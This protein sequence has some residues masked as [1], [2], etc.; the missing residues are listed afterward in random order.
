MASTHTVGDGKT[1]STIQAGIDDV[2]GNRSGQGEGAVEVYAKAGD[3]AETLNT[4]TGFSN[5]SAADF[6]SVTAMVSHDGVRD[7]G[8]IVDV[9]STTANQ[10]ISHGLWAVLDGFCIFASSHKAAST[11]WLINA[12]A[13][14]MVRNCII[15]DCD[16]DT[17]QLVHGIFL[18]GA[19]WI[20]NCDVIGIGRGYSGSGDGNGNGIVAGNAGNSGRHNRIENCTAL[21]CSRCG[22]DQNSQDFT[23]VNNGYA[24]DCATDFT[25][26]HAGSRTFEYCISSDAS[27]GAANNNL[28]TKASAAQFVSVVQG[29]EDLHLVV[30]A[31]CNRSGLDNSARYTDDIEGDL[32]VDW[33][34][35]ADEFVAGN[36]LTGHLATLG[37]G[38]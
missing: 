34:T 3:Y 29:S 30:G 4:I 38:Q 24:G 25:A 8:I 10:P 11:I 32:R 18:N 19:N 35:G 12:F 23:D 22:I 15:Y 21:D 36:G 1:F 6:V 14:A 2:P 37:V 26:T 20:R 16:A 13:N 33:N 31:D 7:A 28:N 5:T 17:G 9:G 27:A